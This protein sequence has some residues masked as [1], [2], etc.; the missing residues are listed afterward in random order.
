MCT[1]KVKQL[2][3]KRGYSDVMYLLRATNVRK[4]SI[5]SSLLEIAIMSYLNN[6]TLSMEQLNKVAL[7]NAPMTIE[8]EEECFYL[9]K[10]ALQSI[11]T[12]KANKLDDNNVVYKFIQNI[13]SEVRMRE[14]I[15]M[16]VINQDLIIDE[17]ITAIFSR[18][19]IRMIMKPDNTFQEVLNHIA[20]REGYDEVEDLVGD[21]Y[22]VVKNE[23][24]EEE[25]LLDE[26]EKELQEL[27]EVFV[28]EHQNLVF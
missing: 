3:L 21:L 6:P 23:S 15:K 28:K 8:N 25:I 9:M 12:R 14:L 11:Y 4:D 10:E 18:T 13:S 7:N 22:K 2:R 19:A 16:R 5:G 24:D 26:K 1:E 27:I 17:N 20:G